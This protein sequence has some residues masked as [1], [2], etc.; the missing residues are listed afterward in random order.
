VR[1]Q[2]LHDSH[3]GE[4]WPPALR[5]A[6]A[7]A[8]QELA[9]NT[10]TGH[11]WQPLRAIDALKGQA[12]AL[13]LWNAW[14]SP[15]LAA[16]AAPCMGGTVPGLGLSTLEYAP[17]AELT[18]RHGLLAPEAL[19]C[20]AP[21]TGNMELLLRFGS[22]GQQAR[23]LRPLLEG[24]IRSCYAMTEPDVASSDAASVQLQIEPAA[25][26]G[27]QPGYRLH[28]RK[29]WVSGAGD[30]RCKLALVLGRMPSDTSSGPPRG[31]AH[32]AH[33]VVLVPMDSPGVHVVRPLSVFGYDD[34]PHGHCEVQF[35]EVWVPADALL[36]GEGRGFEMAQARLGPGRVHHCM[37]VLGLAE[38]CLEALCRRA[39]SRVAFGQLLAEKVLRS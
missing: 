39:K 29:W 19:N 5:T 8:A 23:W 13:G 18:G 4:P 31:G 3:S 12:Q 32:G 10:A 34:A 7:A 1:L 35:R 2:H 14:L 37:R 21:D 33:S 20:S 38:R 6:E 27:G 22:R 16:L 9:A 36:L 25:G 11:R 30:P 26:P 15:E 17:L 28:G 24:R